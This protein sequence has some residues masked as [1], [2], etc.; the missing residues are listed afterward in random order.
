MPLSDRVK[1]PSSAFGST[2]IQVESA[3]ASVFTS[4]P[5]K[6]PA[7]CKVQA[8]VAHGTAPCPS[9]PAA[10]SLS[11]LRCPAPRHRIAATWTWPPC[12]RRRAGAGRARGTRFHSPHARGARRAARRLGRALRRGVHGRVVVFCVWRRWPSL[13]AD[14]LRES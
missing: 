6:M 8:Q 14:D 3:H 12:Q 4:V 2:K 1:H 13:R 5:M 9:F 11:F 7:P 10:Q